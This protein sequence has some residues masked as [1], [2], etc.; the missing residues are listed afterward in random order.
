MA[1]TNGDGVF[2]P[3]SIVTTVFVTIAFYNVFELVIIALSTIRPLCGL[4]FYS[5]I[6]SAIGIAIYLLG[7]VLKTYHLSNEILVFS[8]FLILGWIP[9]VRYLTIS[10]FQ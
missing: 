10:P 2:P 1:G 5:F 3:P 7:I 4:Y 6:G 9:M 8:T